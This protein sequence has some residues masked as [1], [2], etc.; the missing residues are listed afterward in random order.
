[1]TSGINYQIKIGAGGTTHGHDSYWMGKNGGDSQF[2]SLTA[3]GGGGGG[4]VVDTT[5]NCPTNGCWTIGSS[6]GSGGGNSVYNWSQLAA[7]G[8]AGQGNSGG[9]SRNIG[10]TDA[11]GN[12]R[13]GGYWQAGGGGGSGGSPADPQLFV[14]DGRTWGSEWAS[15]T[16]IG[17]GGVGIATNITGAVSY[18]GGGGGGGKDGGQ[19]NCGNNGCSYPT[20]SI[21]GIGGGGNGAY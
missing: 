16:N 1:M 14:A 12:W 11:N 13:G 20:A 5:G 6:G 3:V 2:A 19:T 21:G 10:T 17:N 4:A 18:Y 7:L 8:S 15:N 9:V